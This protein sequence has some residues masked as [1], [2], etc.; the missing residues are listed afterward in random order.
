MCLKNG[1]GQAVD[2]DILVN[3][4]VAR[5]LL[6]ATSV[7]LILLLVSV[8]FSAAIGPVYISPLDVAKVVLHHLPILVHGSH[9]DVSFA[10][11]QI[12]WEIRIPRTFLGILVG[13]CLAMAGAALQGLLLNPLADPYMIGVSSGA[14]LGAGIGVLLGLSGVLL[15]LGLPLVAFGTAILAVSIVYLLAYRGGTVSIL[16]FVLA[17]VV[18]GSF[19][20]AGL[21]FIMTIASRDLERI[22]FWT[23]GSLASSDPWPRV[24]IILPFTV[25]G[26][27][28]L[29]VFARD[30][31]VFSLGE[32]S[33]RYLGL[34][35]ESL[36]RIIIG[37]SALVTAAAVSVSG[38]IGFVGLVVPH[39]ARKLFGSDHRILIPSSAL[40]G[41]TLVVVA[42]TLARTLSEIPIG[43]ITALLGAP[44]FL[45]LLKKTA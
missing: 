44:F 29:S 38:T 43:V 35:V 28:T 10:T 5:R 32:E 14:A 3:S 17:G 16:S 2:N 41:A 1:S 34:E 25:F 8:V 36:K 6:R 45:Y 27:I 30:L 40:L 15:G 37:C 23:M 21:T 20:W 7:L 9:P 39:M 31:N 26:L 12:V 13:M 42:D 11:E 33:A 19:M 22:V 24:L 4:S 18:V